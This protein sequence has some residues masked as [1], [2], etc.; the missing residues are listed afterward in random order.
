MKA[1]PP[2]SPG[3]LPS[4]G[5]LLLVT[6]VTVLY[7]LITPVL[8]ELHGD[9]A[10]IVPGAIGLFLLGRCVLA[11]VPIAPHTVLLVF[12]VAGSGLI[13]AALSAT[14]LDAEA[15]VPK[16]I[17]AAGMGMVLFR[18][19]TEPQLVVA[20]ALFVAAFDI[21]SVARGPASKLIAAQPQAVDFLTFTLPR[22]G[23]GNGAGQL[24]ISD[25]LFLGCW[26]AAAAA[27]RLRP[28]ATA[29]AFL[30]ALLC[31]LVL[32]VALDRALPVLPFLAAAFL[33]PNLDRI[34]L[35][36]RGPE[37]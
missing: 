36:L 13:A 4:P 26:A 17:F 7:F 20:L 27:W 32:T 16:A 11:L 12:L 28:R 34:A 29:A 2:A 37:E 35:I 15:N 10:A 3:T 33:L 1:G 31:P 8:P 30:L 21:W 14:G 5:P 9:A 23:G 6:A 24:G 19:T 22:W 18:V 25:L